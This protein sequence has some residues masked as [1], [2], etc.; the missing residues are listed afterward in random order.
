MTDDRLPRAL[1]GRP[2]WTWERW[3]RVMRLGASA[4]VLYHLGLSVAPEQWEVEGSVY[5]FAAKRGG[6]PDP[7]AMRNTDGLIIEVT[8]NEVQVTLDGNVVMSRIL[9]GGTA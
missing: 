1:Q 5:R 2:G 6:Q 9:A 4:H 8:D 3:D 7:S